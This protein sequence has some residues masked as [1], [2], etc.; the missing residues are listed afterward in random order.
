MIFLGWF[1]S[2]WNNSTWDSDFEMKTVSTS[3]NIHED[4]NDC[5]IMYYETQNRDS[6]I[7]MSDG[8][9]KFTPYHEL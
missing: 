8:T 1:L 4:I 6:L 5:M 2:S 3:F 7:V 9:Q